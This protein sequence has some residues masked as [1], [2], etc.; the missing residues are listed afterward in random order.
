MSR[1]GR[2]TIRRWWRWLEDR[3]SRY[4]F[5]LRSHFPELGR[6]ASQSAFWSACFRCMSLADAMERIEPDGVIIP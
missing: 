6:Y 1:P 4:S 3:F 5:H 2:H